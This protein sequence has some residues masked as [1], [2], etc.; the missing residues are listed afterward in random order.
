MTYASIVPLQRK[1]RTASA[2][3]SAAFCGLKYRYIQ[4]SNHLIERLVLHYY[5]YF[6]R[7]RETDLNL[8][9]MGTMEDHWATTK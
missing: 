2:N 1:I 3:G 7:N 4:R 8:S 6:S 9:A 5:K